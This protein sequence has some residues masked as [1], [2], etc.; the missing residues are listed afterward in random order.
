MIPGPWGGT[1]PLM[2]LAKKSGM[3]NLHL[4][5]GEELRFGLVLVFLDFDGSVAA[6]VRLGIQ[7]TFF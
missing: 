4:W 3:R 5:F 6:N 7:K 2:Q 1:T